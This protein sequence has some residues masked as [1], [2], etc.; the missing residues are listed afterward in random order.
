MRPLR[1]ITVRFSFIFYDYLTRIRASRGWFEFIDVQVPDT[2]RGHNLQEERKG[3]LPSREFAGNGGLVVMYS[4][5][6]EAT[7]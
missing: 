4:Y 5:R 2:D 1:K 3:K 7:H 6:C